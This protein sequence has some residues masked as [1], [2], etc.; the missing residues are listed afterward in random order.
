MQIYEREI[1]PLRAGQ[2]ERCS[3]MIGHPDN[4]VPFA[5]Q[6]TAQRLG[7]EDVVLH[8]EHT[9]AIGRPRITPE[10]ASLC[11]HPARQLQS[12]SAIA[13]AIAS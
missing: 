5:F 9:Q 7:V 6:Q 4:D 12:P 11:T 2:I 3:R 13:R 8:D 10:T 1:G